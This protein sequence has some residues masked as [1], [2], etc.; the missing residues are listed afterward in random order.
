MRRTPAIATIVARLTVS[1]MLAALLAGCESSGPTPVPKVRL[2][3]AD[4]EMILDQAVAAAS[5][6]PSLVRVN[7]AGEKQT[8]RM[9]IIVLNRGTRT[10]GRRSMD[11]AWHGS[12]SI[13]TMKA[14]T[15]IAF[16]SDQNA[17]T[18]RTIGALSQPGGPLWQI[19][20][21]NRGFL[22]PGLIEFPGGVPL[23]KNGV[24][25][26]GIGVSGDGVDEDEAVALAGAVGFEAPEAIRVDK[27]TGGTVPYVK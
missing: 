24:L 2:T 26:G 18:T 9:H 6:Q 27:V 22:Q 8:T 25:V 17:L 1:L 16:S 12:L 4:V 7:A 3:D 20:N 10:I 19:G 5:Q 13:A 23:Y 11:D 15:A 21:S 14:Y